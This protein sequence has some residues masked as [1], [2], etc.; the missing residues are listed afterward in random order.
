MFS[1][2]VPK[3]YARSIRRFFSLNFKKQQTKIDDLTSR[4]HFDRYSKFLSG[5]IPEEGGI[6]VISWMLDI[7]SKVKYLN[8]DKIANL[9]TWCTDRS[10]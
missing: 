1:A 5:S 10:K 3:I 2:Q 4:T 8:T 7:K 6:K 9:G